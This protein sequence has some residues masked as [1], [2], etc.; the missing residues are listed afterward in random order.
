MFLREIEIKNYRSLE[1]IKLDRLGTFNVLIGRN[2]SGKSSVFG[3]L[4]LLNRVIRGTGEVN[5]TDITDQDNKRSLEISLSFETG[6]LERDEILKIL[7]PDDH[8]NNRRLR[9]ADSP[10]FRKV[11][12]SFKSTAGLPRLLHLHETRLLAEDN[13][14]ATVQKLIANEQSENPKNYIKK[15]STS[16]NKQSSCLTASLLD[17][18][19]KK[20]VID[21]PIPVNYV[22]NIYKQ[23]REIIWPQ[24]KLD[25]YLENAFFFN[26]FRHSQAKQVVAQTEELDRDGSNLAAVLHTINSNNRSLLSRIEKF[27]HAALPDVGILQ[28]PLQANV[29]E[30]GFLSDDGGY[31]VRLHDMGGGIEQLLMIATVLLTTGEDST[32][33]IEEPESHLHAGAQRFLIE[34]LIHEGRQVFLTTHSPTLVNIPHSFCMYQVKY[35]QRNTEI[36][37]LEGPEMLGA[38]LA[39]IGSRNSDVLLSNSVV[40]VEGPGDRDTVSVWGKTLEMSLDERNV[41]VLPMGGG[42]QADHKARVR[43]EVL[44]GIS[45]KAPVPHFFVL[46]RDER[47]QAEIQNLQQSLN[48]R[49]HL[50]QRRELENYLLVP[51]AILAAIREKCYN[52]VSIVQQIDQ[53]KEAEISALIQAT[54]DGLYGLVLLKRIRAELGGLPGGLI[55]REKTQLIA[56]KAKSQE[57]PDIIQ[58]EIEQ[59]FHQHL[60]HLNAHKVIQAQKD[61]LDEEWANESKR[62]HLAPGEELLD[63]V[64]KRFGTNYKKSA[65]TRRI[66]AKMTS[67]EIPQEIKDLIKKAFELSS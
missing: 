3:A 17:V 59:N 27:V 37:R 4:S 42:D 25:E 6:N 21:L 30:V 18:N 31:F 11:K 40:F 33:F 52:D 45:Q 23:P 22:G 58:Q 51:R 39:D 54:A 8:E 38:M 50:L 44:A 24:L 64:F 63:A 41:T 57:L 19:D 34:K 67:D 65:D 13:H 46:D 26:P 35:S 36:T 43:S 9:A 49:L 28:T 29:T 32:L 66:A 10:L 1:S 61:A 12:F 2:N 62:L 7:W 47:S 5:K 15:I 53:A 48:K 20:N 16:E 56:A 60:K 14:W 55:P